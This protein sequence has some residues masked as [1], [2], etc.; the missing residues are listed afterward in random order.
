RTYDDWDEDKPG[1]V[2]ADYAFTLNVTDVL[3]EFQVFYKF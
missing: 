1:F 2:K 3:K